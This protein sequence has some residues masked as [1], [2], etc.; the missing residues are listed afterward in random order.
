VRSIPARVA[1]WRWQWLIVRSRRWSKLA[2]NHARDDVADRR[3]RPVVDMGQ[4]RL[5]AGTPRRVPVSRIHS[6]INEAPRGQRRGRDCEPLLPVRRIRSRDGG[7]RDQVEIL[8]VRRDAAG[9]VVGALERDRGVNDH[10][11]GVRHAR[12][13]VNP[14]RHTRRSQ[15][16]NPAR[17]SARRAPVGDHP[18]INAALLGP[19]ERPTIPEPTVKRIGADQDLAL[20]GLYRPVL[21]GL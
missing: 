20:G 15:R 7:G 2:D 18:D 5:P 16:V 19:D 4:R 11:F 17:R 8:G 6:A 21:G 13:I 10:R 1:H 9:P 14:H 12:A 3:A